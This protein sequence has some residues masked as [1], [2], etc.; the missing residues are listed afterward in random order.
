MKVILKSKKD[1]HYA[2][3]D[4]TEKGIK[5]EENGRSLPCNVSIGKNTPRL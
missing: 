5:I 1:T 4:F 2:I 3:G